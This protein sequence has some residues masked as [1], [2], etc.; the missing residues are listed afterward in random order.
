MPTTAVRTGVTLNYQVFGEGDPLLLIMGTS[1]SIPLWAD[2][3][4]RLAERYRV[5]AF[6]NRGLGGSERGEG[7][8]SVAS[9]AEDASALPRGVE[10]RGR[11]CRVVPRLGDPAGNR[12]R[13]PRAGRHRR[14]VCNLGR[15]RWIPTGDAHGVAAAVRIGDMD[16]ALAS[17][18]AFSPQLSTIPPSGSCSR[19]MR[20]AFPQTQ[21]QMAVTVEQWDADLV[22]DTRIVWVRSLRRPSSSSE[23]RTAYPALAGQEGRGRDSRRAVRLVTGP[24]P[25][26]APFERLEDLLAITHGFLTVTRWGKGLAKGA[27]EGRAEGRSGARAKRCPRQRLHDAI[28]VDTDSFPQSSA[29]RRWRPV[30]AHTTKMNPSSE[31][32]TAL[33]LPTAD[34]P[35]PRRRRRL[36]RLTEGRRISVSRL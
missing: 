5:I 16:S 20:P 15:V 28:S 21:D 29:T 36:R 3:L 12:A 7:P 8:I 23:S 2:L 24:G 35:H 31:P 32:T 4:P 17:G 1:G 9:L 22:H 33:S 14:H 34:G 25:P 10:I 27:P 26:R 19:P 18:L 30:R 13:P 6:D 11:I